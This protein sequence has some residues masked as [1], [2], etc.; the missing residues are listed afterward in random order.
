MS[1]FN[2]EWYIVQ[3]I[4][5]M[6]LGFIDRYVYVIILPLYVDPVQGGLQLPAPPL[7]HRVVEVYRRRPFPVLATVKVH[8][9]LDNTQITYMVFKSKGENFFFYI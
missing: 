3:C 4:L 9:N 8:T 5:F 2:R 6:Y 7:V 1:L